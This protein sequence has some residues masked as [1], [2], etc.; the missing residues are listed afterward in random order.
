[1]RSKKMLKYLVNDVL[2]GLSEDLKLAIYIELRKKF[3]TE[4]DEVHD[5]KVKVSR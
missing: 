2:D 4:K 1:M 3:S 5:Q